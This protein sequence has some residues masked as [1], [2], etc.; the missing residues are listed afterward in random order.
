MIGV[1][2]RGK[3][4]SMRC[5]EFVELVTAYLEGQLDAVTERRFVAHLAECDG[6]DRYLD[7]IRGTVRALG[8]LTPESLTPEARDR[9][10]AAFRGWSA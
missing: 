9:L 4:S 8:E 5:D 3:G 2:G 6:C 7:Q 10:L 1:R